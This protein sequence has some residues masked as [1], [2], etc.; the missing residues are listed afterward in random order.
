M[1]N[2]AGVTSLIGTAVGLGV[3]VGILGLAFD[4]AGR[5][6]ESGRGNGKRR[7]R[8]NPLFDF[9]T[10][11]RP[12]DLDTRPTRK[13]RQDVFGA[14]LLAQQRPRGKRRRNNVFGGELF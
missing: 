6:I 7:R 11:A 9:D 1:S 14:T 13:Q 5:A 2:L 8:R 12:F 3:T 10:G 4:F